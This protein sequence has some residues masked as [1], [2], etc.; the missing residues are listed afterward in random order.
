MFNALFNESN[1]SHVYTGEKYYIAN[2]T[3]MF[4]NP[5][6]I[7]NK[8][9]RVFI[10]FGGADP[11]NYTDRLLEMIIKTE[12]K[13]YQFI[14]VLGRAKKNVVSLLEYNRYPNVEVL[15]DVENM[16][17]LMSSCDIAA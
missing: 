2:K 9:E 17:E 3:F 5:I 11:Q 16:P 12:Y 8:V 4:Y 6:V 10:S 15:Y 7:K 1:L 13:S 14:V